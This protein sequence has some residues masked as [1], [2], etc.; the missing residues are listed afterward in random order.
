ML[1]LLK[2]YD[3]IEVNE[4]ELKIEEIA[5]ILMSYSFTGKVLH[6]GG[7]VG[8]T[9]DLCCVLQAKLPVTRFGTINVAKYNYSY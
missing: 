4:M 2:M 9:W 3:W 7:E 1:R 6:S 8:C 5:V